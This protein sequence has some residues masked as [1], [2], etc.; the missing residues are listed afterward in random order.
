MFYILGEVG[1]RQKKVIIEDPSSLGESMSTS[2][3]PS[4]YLS[5]YLILTKK[6]FHDHAWQ[7]YNSTSVYKQI[8]VDF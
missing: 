1:A 5:S 3:S 8:L 6:L 4:H 7:I 2:S